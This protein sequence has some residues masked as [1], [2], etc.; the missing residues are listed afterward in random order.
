MKSIKPRCPDEGGF[1]LIEVIVASAIFAVISMSL[2]QS[3]FGFVRNRDRTVRNSMAMQLAVETMESFA[4]QNPESLSDANDTT[5]TVSFQGI[6]FVRTV[7]VTVN[8]D[9]SRSVALQIE[10]VNQNRGGSAVIQ[11]SF[12]LWGTR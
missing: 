1:G 2:L 6:D 9:R 5:E 7:D 11:N 10:S 3:T 4:A 8:S 12:A